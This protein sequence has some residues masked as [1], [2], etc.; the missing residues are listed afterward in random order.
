MA[1]LVGGQEQCWRKS[2]GHLGRS[3]KLRKLKNAKKVKRGPTD[4]PTNRRSTR[5]KSAVLGDK[6]KF[7]IN[8]ND[9]NP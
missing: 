2:L 1:T 5:L 6:L 8:I 3:R 9:Q 7:L 4:Q